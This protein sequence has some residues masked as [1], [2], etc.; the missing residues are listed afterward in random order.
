MNKRIAF[1][2]VV[3][4]LAL[5][6]SACNTIEQRSERLPRA[7]LPETVSAASGLSTAWQRSLPGRCAK[8]DV[9]RSLVATADRLITSDCQGNVLALDAEDGTVVWQQAVAD[10]IT[11]G[12][13]L[14]GDTVVVV[15]R[16]PSL[17]ALDR[18]SGAVR[19]ERDLKSESLA[20]PVVSKNEILLHSLDDNLTA[21]RTQDGS[22]I[23][24]YQSLPLNLV[25][26]KSSKPVIY[27][28]QV[29]AG[30]AD[31]K[32]AVFDQSTGEMLWANELSAPTGRYEFQRMVDVSAD[33]VVEQNT[34]FA[35]NY[36]GNLKALDIHTGESRWQ[37]AVSAFSGLCVTKQRVVVSDS[38]G[39]LLALSRQTGKVLW[40][41]KGLS[42]RLLSTPVLFDGVLW[43]GDDEG[44][45]HGLDPET[46]AYAYRLKVDSSAVETTPIVY[47][48]RIYVLSKGGVLK[49]Y[50]VDE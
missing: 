37:Q 6:L 26:R 47:E 24:Q 42:G 10:K 38:Q 35:V 1:L 19:W 49:A 20:A 43:V 25:L 46:G 36:H 22:E 41:Q 4:L 7:P 50:Q 39:Q 21:F 17:V 30:F 33:P 5:G 2:S 23:W 40:E 32:L 3:A 14:G 48:D 45:L 9:T 44:Y 31:G 13:G 29:V 28:G 15:T 34:V 8:Q 11:A 12:P 27:H 16:K 18:Q